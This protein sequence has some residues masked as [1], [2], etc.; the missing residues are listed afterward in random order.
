MTEVFFL[1]DGAD[2]TEY[3]TQCAAE[4]AASEVIDIAR[5]LCDPW[6][7]EWTSEIAIY[8]ASPGH[9]EPDEDGRLVA[10][11]REVKIPTPEGMEDSG[12][13][14]WCDY[15]VREVGE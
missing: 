15:V 2:W 11:V 12:V 4:V 9:G 10:C 5:E 14:Y 3:A 13:C 8:T 6:W 1:W 7:P